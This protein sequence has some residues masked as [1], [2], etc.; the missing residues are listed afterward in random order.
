MSLIREV[1]SFERDNLLVF[2]NLSASE[3]SPDKRVF[4]FGRG[5]VRGRLL[6]NKSL[7]IFMKQKRCRK[8]GKTFYLLFFFYYSYSGNHQCMSKKVNTV[9]WIC[10]QKQD[11]QGLQTHRF[12]SGLRF[13][14]TCISFM[15]FMKFYPED[16]SFSITKKT[17][18]KQQQ[19]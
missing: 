13:M 11:W 17:T 5:L 12:F 7:L 9:C 2:Y 8:G 6:Y 1:A 16:C 18:K 4:F 19:I 10:S 3:I 15:C 14:C